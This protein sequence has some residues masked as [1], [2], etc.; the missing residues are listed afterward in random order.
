MRNVAQALTFCENFYAHS[1]PLLTSPL[2][3]RDI[4]LVNQ[5]E[6]Y[7]IRVSANIGEP[8][9]L[10]SHCVHI[11]FTPS[12]DGNRSFVGNSYCIFLCEP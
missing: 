5:S 8:A 7:L 10:Y 9:R 12:Y 2:T 3:P 11:S 4:G 6:T 1:L